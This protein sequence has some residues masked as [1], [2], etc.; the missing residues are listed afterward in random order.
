MTSDFHYYS[1]LGPEALI[2]AE[3]KWQKLGPF[4]VQHGSSSLAYATLQHGMEYFVSEEWG[5]L[6]FTTATHPIFARKP[7]RI[8]LADPICAKENLKSLLR[9][10][11]SVHPHAVFATASLECAAALRELKFSANCVGYEPELGIPSYNTAGNWK[12]LDMIKRARNEAK[13]EGITIREVDITS[14]P[15]EELN[16][17]SAQWIGG[18]K[19]NDREIWVY[20]RRPLYIP[21]TDVRKF[22]AFNKEGKAVGYVFYDPIYRDGTVIGYAANIVRCDERTYGRLA[23]A[24]H[25]AAMDVF[26]P[27]GKEVLNLMLC[28]FTR[29]DEGAHNDDKP[30]SWFFK[31][32]ERYGNE[33]YNFKGLSFHKSKYRGSDRFIYFCSNSAWPSN[34]V[35]L[36]FLT[37]DITNSYFKTMGQL[38]KGIMKETFRKPPAK[39]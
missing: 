37:S 5:Y 23:T 6:A 33:I 27:E 31:I 17:L 13:R 26:K 22:V 2:S 34:D 12:E 8:V 15:V 36:A 35:Y 4:L 3:E 7:K 9:L 20:A 14:I 11:L 19:V 39:N 25:M 29:I 30:T 18:K 28:P 32:S 38:L 16:A 1:L 21:E 24:I 10:F